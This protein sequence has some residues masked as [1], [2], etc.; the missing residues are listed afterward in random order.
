MTCGQA[1]KYVT[2]TCNGNLPLRTYPGCSI[3]ELY[4]LPDW[5][6]VS[7]QT[8]PRAEYLW[9]NE[10]VIKIHSIIPNSKNSDEAER[11][12]S[13]TF[14]THL[15]KFI[16]MSYRNYVQTNPAKNKG[17]LTTYQSIWFWNTKVYKLIHVKLDICQCLCLLIY[18]PFMVLAAPFRIISISTDKHT[19]YHSRQYTI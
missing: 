9:M 4:Q 10:L 14:S 15:T 1:A 16:S 3:P 11:T 7:D 19:A 13:G 6:L 18:S 2:I 17:P 5:A 12:W 8:G